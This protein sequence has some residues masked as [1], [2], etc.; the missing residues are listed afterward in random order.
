[1]ES[2]GE[3]Q[4][5]PSRSSKGALVKPLLVGESNPYGSSPAFAL[6]PSPQGCTG[7]RLC[8]LIMALD[9]DDYLERFDRANLCVG[10]WSV[11]KAR[12]A[13]LALSL[14]HDD[15]V[16]VLLGAKV[17]T[18]FGLPFRPFEAVGPN[19][20]V[21]PHPSGLNRMWGEPDAFERA[22]AV[23]REAGVL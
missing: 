3:A 15:G 6:Y 14:K 8:H 12:E 5:A 18:G 16:I 17:C 23:L 11:P 4:Q 19:R 22:R 1:V 7:H 10:K 20:V 21:L 9:E 13:A 2:L